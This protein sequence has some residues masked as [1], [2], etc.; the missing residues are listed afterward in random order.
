MLN[1]TLKVV[2]GRVTE[3]YKERIDYLFTPEGKD[4]RNPRNRQVVRSI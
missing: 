3:A 2:R 4:I 1:S